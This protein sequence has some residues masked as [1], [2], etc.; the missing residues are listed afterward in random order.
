MQILTDTNNVI[1]R[2]FGNIAAKAPIGNTLGKKIGSERKKSQHSAAD[3]VAAEA[4]IG[5]TH[6]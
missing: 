1:G 3:T 6:I 2:L 5:N 4:Q